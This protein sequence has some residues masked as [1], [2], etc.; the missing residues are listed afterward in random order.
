MKRSQIAEVISWMGKRSY[1][2][3]LEHLGIERLQEIARETVRTALQSSAFSR[4]DL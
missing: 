2:A 1:A 4:T 3:R